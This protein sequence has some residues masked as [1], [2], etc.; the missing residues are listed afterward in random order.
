[1]EK[2]INSEDLLPSE[3]FLSEVLG[4]KIIQDDHKIGK[5][6]DLVIVETGKLPEVTHLYVVRQFGKH[7]N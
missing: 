5:L 2:K 6:S 1:M 4:A 7:A 3:F